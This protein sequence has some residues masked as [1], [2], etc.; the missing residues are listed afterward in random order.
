VIPDLPF[1]WHVVEVLAVVALVWLFGSFHLSGAMRWRAFGALLT[2]LV[3]LVWPVGDLAGQ[4]SLSMT[5][6]Q[7]L[8][9]MLLVV[10]LLLGAAPTG[11]LVKVTKPV[12][13]DAFVRVF[14][15]PLVAVVF[16]TILG[17]L[18]V[19]PLIVDWSATSTAGRLV[20]LA[21]TAIA[22][23]VLW[24]P[25]LPVVPG[26]RKLS[27]TGRAGY[28]FIS[29]LVVTVLS[30]VWIFARHPLYPALHGQE[31]IFH[32]TP[33]LDQQL[34]GFVAKFGAYIPMWL[35]AYYTFFHAEDEG[36]PVEES[37]L[38]WIDV[39]RHLL[40][41]DRARRRAGRSR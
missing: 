18:T 40:R 24:L 27:P 7:R 9:I 31:A 10:P 39:E 28:I 3:A 36:R 35:I 14:Y 23:L 34:A 4:V 11:W 32:I 33:L 21:L 26:A 15:P 6:I 20:S 29:S 38:H 8:V 30:F 12:V 13:V 22:G 41:A 16:V 5:V 19:S 1:H 2:L 37:P 17:T 25:G